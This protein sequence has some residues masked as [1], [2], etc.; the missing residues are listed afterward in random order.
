MTLEALL[1][2]FGVDPAVLF[3][4]L[5]GATVGTT[6]SVSVKRNLAWLVFICVVLVSALAGGAL[7]EALGWSQKVRMFLACVFAAFFH[8]LVQTV[9]LQLPAALAAIRVKF[10]GGNP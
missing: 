5:V 3:W 10:L 2:S 6:V 4:A 8:P 7:G 1:A 9:S